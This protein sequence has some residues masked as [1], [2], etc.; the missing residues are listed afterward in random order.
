MATVS[1]NYNNIYQNLPFVVSANPNWY[2]VYGFT[3][4]ATSGTL[5]DIRVNPTATLGVF[6]VQ[7]CTGGTTWVDTGITIPSYF[8]T[9][10][11]ESPALCITGLFIIYPTG[12]AGQYNVQALTVSNSGSPTANGIYY[13]PEISAAPSGAITNQVAVVNAVGE[14]YFWTGSVWNDLNFQ[15]PNSSVLNTLIDSNGA[16]MTFSMFGLLNGSVDAQVYNGIGTVPSSL[17]NNQSF[18][19]LSLVGNFHFDLYYWNGAAYEN[20]TATLTLPFEI[21]VAQGTGVPHV[22]FILSATGQF[23]LAVRQPVGLY[24]ELPIADNANTPLPLGSNSTSVPGTW[25]LAESVSITLNTVVTNPPGTISPAP[26]KI[27]TSTAID[28]QFANTSGS[29]VSN[30]SITTYTITTTYTDGSQKIITTEYTIG[31]FYWFPDSP[32]G[33][34]YQWQSIQAYNNDDTYAQ[35]NSQFGIQAECQFKDPQTNI[36]YVSKLNPVG[37]MDIPL[38]NYLCGIFYPLKGG[39][40]Q[41]GNPVTLNAGQTPP[42]LAL[43]KKVQIAL[44]GDGNAYYLLGGTWNTIPLNTRYIFKDTFGGINLLGTGNNV[45][46]VHSATRLTEGLVEK[47]AFRNMTQNSPAMGILEGTFITYYNEVADNLVGN[48]QFSPVMAATVNEEPALVQFT[49]TPNTGLVVAPTGSS[50][51]FMY[52]PAGLTYGVPVTVTFEYWTSGVKQTKAYILE[53]LA[54]VE[55]LGLAEIAPAA[56]VTLDP[57]TVTPGTIF[58]LTG[59]S[60]VV[61]NWAFLPGSPNTW[62][63]TPSGEFTANATGSYKVNIDIPY[64]LSTPLTS[65]SPPIVN[66]IKNITSTPVTVANIPFDAINVNE[67]TIVGQFVMA[68]GM[69]S[70]ESIINLSSGDTLDLQYNPNGSLA[71]FSFGSQTVYGSGSTDTNINS[72]PTF[73]VVRLA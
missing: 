21:D 36:T 41:N 66:I 45:I 58:N 38:V 9:Q 35:K 65:G 31:L 59:P 40:V 8:Q 42:I 24:T 54:P 49:M 70:Y 73:G 56:P 5:G 32:T 44:V 72:L 18:L 6:N 48:Q 3:Q 67:N 63:T 61:N 23:N 69:L 53:K 43:A 62:F 22:R 34:T 28:Q 64:T 13:H 47:Y 1:P 71:L 12:T 15:N 37:V 51:T 39:S 68:T 26:S 52:D 2:T 60:T 19:L 10:T 27:E 14:M 16:T 11:G 29:Q 55:G 50:N 7:T 20:T 30:Q 17:V 33:T 46:I 57:T 25:G 4:G